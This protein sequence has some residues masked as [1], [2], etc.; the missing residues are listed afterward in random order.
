MTGRS[1]NI[2]TVYCFDLMDLKCIHFASFSVLS[3]IFFLAE[4]KN[5][6]CLKKPHPTGDQV[7]KYLVVTAEYWPAEEFGVWGYQ[8]MIYIC[9]FDSQKHET[10][11]QITTVLHVFR[12]QRKG[13]NLITFMVDVMVGS[14]ALPPCGQII[15]RQ[16]VSELRRICLNANCIGLEM[17]QTGNKKHATATNV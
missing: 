6:L 14:S 9:K 2:C 15:H 7:W 16:G 13:N 5:P 11:S 8:R 4:I 12:I 10:S 1:G 17:F 3:S